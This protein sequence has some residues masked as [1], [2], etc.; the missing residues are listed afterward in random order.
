MP[1]VVFFVAPSFV[2][3]YVFSK[4]WS[5]TVAADVFQIWIKF[6]ITQV[7]DPLLK[8][9]QR[10]KVVGDFGGMI[11]FTVIAVAGEPWNLQVTKASQG[12][13]VRK[14]WMTFAQIWNEIPIVKWFFLW[15]HKT[16]VFT[17]LQI[18]PWDF[19]LLERRQELLGGSRNSPQRPQLQGLMLAILL[20]PHKD[21]PPRRSP[22]R[23]GVE[24][25]LNISLDG[26]FRG[27]N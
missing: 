13:Q 9:M 3:L 22:R 4:L 18:L 11:N 14:L 16:W 20:A 15:Y 12:S 1:I 25:D 10:P 8:D 5:E 2:F 23:K 26:F 24:F 19:F 6:W 27:G 7:D 17:W 21:A